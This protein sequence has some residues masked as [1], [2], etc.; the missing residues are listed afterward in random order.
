MKWNVMIGTMVAVGLLGTAQVRAQET[1]ADSAAAA[2]SAQ[3]NR[4]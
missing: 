2:T 4:G 1:A 3:Q